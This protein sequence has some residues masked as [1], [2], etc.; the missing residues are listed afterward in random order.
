MARLFLLACLSLLLWFP[1]ACSKCG[2]DVYLTGP[3]LA[4]N[5]AAV[6]YEA[7]GGDI[8]FDDIKVGEG[9]VAQ[10]GRKFSFQVDAH[11]E[12]GNSL[13]S[14]TLTFLD[15]P[16]STERWG[17]G[18]DSGTVPPEFLGGIRGM[19]EGGI[20]RFTLPRLDPAHIYAVTALV[21][22]EGRAVAH[23]S[24]DSSTILTATLIRVCRPRFCSSKSYQI[25]GPTVVRKAQ[26]VS[27]R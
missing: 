10:P 22:T 5:R 26:E 27:C 7:E 15:P 8:P 13:G 11:D 9:R 3:D 19:R 17:Y 23:L 1:L 4:A 25:P 12:Q 21:D 20:R 2:D 24:H 6:I 18:I 14:G 16:F